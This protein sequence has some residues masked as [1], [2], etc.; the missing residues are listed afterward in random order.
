VGAETDADERGIQRDLEEARKVGALE[1][2]QDLAFEQRNWRVQRLGWAAMALFVLAGLTG[3][4]GRGLLASAEAASPGGLL[5]VHYDRLARHGAP[6]ELRLAVAPAAIDDG[7]VR[8]LISRPFLEG[9][10][11]EDIQPAPASS[12]ASGDALLYAFHVRP[13]EQAHIL[14][15]VVPDSQGLRTADISLAGG[16]ERVSIRQFVFP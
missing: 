11:I 16:G 3:A 13:G 5:R 8:I 2:R 15:R 10:R 4:F 9:Q 1:I 7:T 6:G 14:I 12:L